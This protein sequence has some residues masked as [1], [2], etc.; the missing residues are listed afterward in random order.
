MAGAD[1]WI[2]LICPPGAESGKISHGDRE[3]VPYR[4]DVENPR[5][6][7]LVKVPR[8]CVSFVPGRR[9]LPIE[10]R[11]SG[12]DGLEFAS[13]TLERGDRLGQPLSRRVRHRVGGCVSHEARERM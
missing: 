11:R 7:W 5:S 13:R 1:G 12:G 2:V 4:E 8:G 3:F 6:R 10:R 9:V